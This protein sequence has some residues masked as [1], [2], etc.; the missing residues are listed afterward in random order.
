M[1]LLTSS[2]ATPKPRR[3]R[4]DDLFQLNEHR[5]L[6]G[7]RSG[8]CTRVAPS[9]LKLVLARECQTLSDS[10][11]GLGGRSV[12][13]S[14]SFPSERAHYPP[15]ARVCSSSGETIVSSHNSAQRLRKEETP[16]RP[17]SKLVRRS[18]LHLSTIKGSVPHNDS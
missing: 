3:R 13:R 15:D 8:H 10:P 12:D 7:P 2:L 16:P 6:V 5:R 14:D 4:E 17:V 9:F 18:W 11:E 1:K